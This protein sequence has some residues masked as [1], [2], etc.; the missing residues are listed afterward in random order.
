MQQNAYEL[1]YMEAHV[2]GLDCDMNAT[3]FIR[4]PVRTKTN[5]CETNQ[6]EINATSRVSFP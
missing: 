4:S 2:L 3:S 1:Q 6:K 5:E